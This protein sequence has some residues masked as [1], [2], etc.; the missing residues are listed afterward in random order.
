MPYPL[1]WHDAPIDLSF[2]FDQEK[3]A[4]KRGFLT[5]SGNQFVFEDGTAAR[6][7]GT[8]F[9]SG[10]NFPSHEYSRK[11]A[12]RLAKFGVNLVR[13]HQMDAEWSTPNL[14]QFA[15]GENKH[16]TLELDR[17]SL[18]RLDYL[19]YCLKQEG[20]YMYLDLLTYR[21]FKSG[22]GVIH[23]ELLGEGAKPYSN[24]NLRLIELQK[25]YAE[26]LF[27]HVNPY[28]KL[29]YKDD[30][31]IALAGLANEN[32]LFSW[33]RTPVVLEPYRSELEQMYREWAKQYGR[34]VP[35]PAGTVRFDVEPDEAMTAFRIELQSKYYQEMIGHL[36]SIGVRIPISGTNW[37]INAA[38]L[39][40]QTAT[41]FT[42]NHAYWWIG[43]QQHI[44][45]RPMTASNLNILSMLGFMRLPDKPMF[46]SEWDSPWPN[47][48]RAE[49]PLLLAAAGCFQGWS[50][51]A[52][53]TYRYTTTTDDDRIGR[54]IMLNGISYRGV[55]DTFNDP[56]KFGLFYHAALLM[57]RGDV[58]E[59]ERLVKVQLSDWNST[60]AD[61][62]YIYWEC[63][64]PATQLLTERHKY[65]IGLPG[66]EHAADEVLSPGDVPVDVDK[67]E[68]V[69]DTGEMYRSWDK[70][71]GWIDSPRTKAVYGFVGD[72]GVI[73]LQGMTVEALTDFATIAVSS[74]TDEPLDHSDSILLTAVGR[75]DNTGAEYNED[76]T[77]ELMPGSPPIRIEIIQ[78]R[79]QLLTNETALRV[80]SVN[81]EGF[82]TGE[83]PS[84]VED[85]V[86]SFELG[87]K[88]P[89]MYYLIQK[90]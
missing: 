86:L 27:T 58:R 9:N 87:K 51:Y 74:L 24:F 10:A 34:E 73:E 57:R 12:K 31:A 42:D 45:N 63:R 35:Q 78:S 4:G 44:D 5:V 62:R 88:Y 17:E 18:D 67:G 53:H 76:H 59:G 6:F 7:W 54:N 43:D 23:A 77:S 25:R 82:Y 2:V 19:M 36:R 70:R 61:K 32:E 11:V 49:T 85:G 90:Q 21:R 15:K 8:N 22:D 33:K 26:Q 81:P 66:D 89:S 68:I 75:S 41:D 56:A 80:W 83:V 37:P 64:M 1:T 38:L 50:G 40:T 69:S 60:Y 13:F 20:I 3:P 28:T 39:Q 84:H 16:S 71:Y 48:W 47:E 72:A 14:F 29:A 79:I 30:P 52:I 65:A 55:F 46:V